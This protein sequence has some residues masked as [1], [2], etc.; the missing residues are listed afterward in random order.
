VF[1]KERKDAIIEQVGGRDRCLLLVKLGER[2][3]AIGVDEGL[4]IDTANAF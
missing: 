3:F 1:F 4:L 2:D